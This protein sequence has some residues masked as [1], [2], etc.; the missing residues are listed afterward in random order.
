MS[1]TKSDAPRILTVDIETKPIDAWTWSLWDTTI[2]IN[3]IKDPGGPMCAAWKWLGEKDVHFS[4]EW[5]HKDRFAWLKPLR[6]AL[7]EADAVVTQ[8]GDKF[9]LPK[10]NG[11][12][13]MAGMKPLP[14]ITSID[15]RKA[16]KK[17][18]FIS[19]RLDFVTQLL[20][21]GRK[22]KHEGFELW[23]KVMNGDEKARAK[24]ERYNKH[25]VV[26][27]ERYYKRIRPFIQ[28]HPHLHD[29]GQCPI[30]GSKHIRAN[31]WRRTRTMK[32]QRLQ[33]DACGHPFKGTSQRVKS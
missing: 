13:M 6:E 22:L 12:L 11:W 29:H 24:M 8:N 3:Q 18:G 33:C 19:T 4:A 27:T 21:I 15:V 31:G 2:G 26:I 25:D 9:D 16:T 28:N 10:I 17:F 1:K 20:K 14:N 32:Y 23:I 30:C 5:Q 7:A